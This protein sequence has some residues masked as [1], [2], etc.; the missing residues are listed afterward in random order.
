[1]NRRNVLVGVVVLAAAGAALWKLSGHDFIGGRQ[2][3]PPAPPAV[4]VTAGA[5]ATQNV[6]VYVRGLGTVQAFQMVTV[7]TRVDGQIT[8]VLF[9][10]G[11]EVKSG[12]PLFEIDPRPFQAALT[13]AQAAKQRDEAQL[14]G[15]QL[16]LERYAKLLPSGFQTRQQYDQQIATVGQLKGTIAADE[17][18]IE[19]ATLNLQYTD[20]RS[21]IDGRTGARLVDLGNFVQAGQGTALVTIAQLKPIFVSFTVPQDHLVDIRANQAR[22]ALDVEA[23]ASDDKTL[24]SRGKLSLIDNQVDTTTGT[25][26]LKATFDNTDERLWPGEFVSARLILAVRQDAVVVPAQTVMQ[27]PQGAYIYVIKPDQ[28]VDRRTVEVAATQDN[29]AVIGKGLARGERVVVDGQYRLTQGAKV[30]VRQDDNQ[31]AMA[32]QP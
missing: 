28:T 7:R 22:G 31:N 11:Q 27:G 10:E 13:Q 9:T 21:P 4:P 32:G 17:A 1:V 15:A 5:A 3:P 24:L 30:N 12:D 2:G 6:P 8:K 14:Q 25:I 18:Q 19:N 26:H 23:Y 20:I 16:D 29:L